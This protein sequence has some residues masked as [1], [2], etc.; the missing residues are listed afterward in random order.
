MALLPGHNQAIIW[1]NAD[2]QS[3]RP[4]GTYFNEILF[5]IQILSFKKMHLNM[6]AVKWWPCEAIEAMWRRL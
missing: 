4:Q 3:I 2:I 6:S 1:T 5:E